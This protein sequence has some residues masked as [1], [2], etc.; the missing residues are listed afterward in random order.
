MEQFSPN[1]KQNESG[2]EKS[3]TNS[4]KYN[5]ILSTEVISRQRVSVRDIID[6]HYKRTR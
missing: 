2:T 6:N 3:K 5:S 1:R 4:Q